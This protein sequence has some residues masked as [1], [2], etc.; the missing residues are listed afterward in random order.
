MTF[1]VRLMVM[2]LPGT[3]SP[4]GETVASALSALGF[5]AL[6]AMTVGK[7]YEWTTEAPSA[8]AARGEAE[9]MART[10]LANPVSERATVLEVREVGA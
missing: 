4:E 5:G 6:G 2:P 8:D 7:L 3:R 9:A 1:S 10:L